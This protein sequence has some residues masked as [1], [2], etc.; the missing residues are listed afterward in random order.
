MMSV[1]VTGTRRGA[2][3]LGLSSIASVD[4]KTASMKDYLCYIL[5]LMP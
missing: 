1:R 4:S 5:G 3:C 2:T